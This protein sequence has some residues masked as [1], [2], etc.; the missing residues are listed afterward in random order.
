MRSRA[1]VALSAKLVD[2][3]RERFRAATD[4]SASPRV[5]VAIDAIE[6]GDDAR[7]ADRL[8]DIEAGEQAGPALRRTLP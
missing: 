2:E 8:D 3:E 1:A 4:A 5:R 7:L 6:D